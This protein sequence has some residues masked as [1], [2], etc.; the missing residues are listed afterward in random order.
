MRILLALFIL[1]PIFS[2]AQSN[3]IESI[4]NK[5][6]DLIDQIDTSNGEQ[7]LYFP[8]K[9][10]SPYLVNPNELVQLDSLVIL[11]VEL[12]FTTFKDEMSFNQIRLNRKRLNNLETAYPDI[13]NKKLIT[14]K[15]T[16][17]TGC[18][19]PEAGHSFFHGFAI[20]YRLPQTSESTTLEVNYLKRVKTELSKKKR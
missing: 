20:H 15:L 4:L 18:S 7:I 17:Q 14:W 3:K 5:K 13:F 19:T 12:V 1:L 6:V 9:F 10:A 8:T 11:K 2:I 16:G